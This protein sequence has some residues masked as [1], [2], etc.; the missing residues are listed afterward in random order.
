MSV[1]LLVLP[2]R[3]ENFP[4]PKWGVYIGDASYTI[5]LSHPFAIGAI[6]QILLLL[7]W[8]NVIHPWFMFV[9]I[10]LVSIIGGCLAY[11]IIEKPLLSFTKGLVYK[12]NRKT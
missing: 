7:G 12:N 10:F 1:L 11:K 6:T 3:A 5:Y 4:M 9:T 8:Q 2:Q